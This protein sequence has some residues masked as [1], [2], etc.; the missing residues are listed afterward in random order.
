MN[1]YYIYI[2]SVF[3][4]IYLFIY[5]IIRLFMYL[6]VQSSIP[7]SLSFCLLSLFIS[8]PYQAIYLYI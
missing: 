4:S 8:L 6:I 5:L 1:L 7:P 2:L 3:Q